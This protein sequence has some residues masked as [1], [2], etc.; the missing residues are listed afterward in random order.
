MHHHHSV[1]ISCH[2]PP[3]HATLT[4]CSSKHS[5]QGLCA[6]CC[7]CDSV[8][9]LVYRAHTPHS[10]QLSAQRSP[11]RPFGSFPCTKQCPPQ[12]PCQFFS[13]ALTLV[14][15]IY[16]YMFLFSV[17]ELSMM[18]D[19]VRTVA[20]ETAF[21]RSLKNCSEHVRGEVSIMYHFS[22]EGY[23]Q[24]LALRHRKQMSLFMIFKL[25]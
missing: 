20:Q 21:Q 3:N 13:M 18:W 8:S 1:L 10:L 19:K 11:M 22:E 14:S 24:R 2:F 17:C 25:F 9:L 5:P 4:P 15:L 23:V 6:Y 7:L 12:S 16:S